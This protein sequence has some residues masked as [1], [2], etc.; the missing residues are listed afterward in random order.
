VER[1]REIPGA[2]AEVGCASGSST[3]FLNK[4][5][6]AQGIEKPYFALDTFSGFVAEDVQFEVEKRGKARNFFNGFQAN[7]KKWFDATMHS[8]AITR[9]RSIEV[10]VN[11]Y[12]LTELG[13]F[14]FVLLD[15]DLYRPSRK[16]LPELYRALSPGSIMVVD[17]CDATN[18]RWDG[19]DQAY[20]EFMRDIEKPA[21]IVHHKLG[22]VR[23]TCG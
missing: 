5:M 22:V 7:K 14:S 17:D 1:T 20:K 12:D 19:A 23:K 11:R 4:Y 16:A 6:D 13:A 21:E 9:V 2:I 15:V 18:V 8:N 10:D 3:V